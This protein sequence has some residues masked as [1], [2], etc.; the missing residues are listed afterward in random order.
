MAQNGVKCA[1][2]KWVTFPKQ[3]YA[4]RAPFPRSVP[5]SALASFCLISS[6]F[7]TALS[8]FSRALFVRFR[9]LS[10]SRLHLAPGCRQDTLTIPH[11]LVAFRITTHQRS[12]G[13]SEVKRFK[14]HSRR[15]NFGGR[16][17]KRDFDGR[18]HTF[19]SAASS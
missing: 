5:P 17:W 18:F 15:L 7:V 12:E 11:S 16:V 13:R 1:V 8:S 2:H 3:D 9:S 4:T 14:A 10:P 19:V 6:H